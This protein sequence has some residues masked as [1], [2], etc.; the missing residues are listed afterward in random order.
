SKLLVAMKFLERK[1]N[2]LVNNLKYFE[3]YLKVLP[4]NSI[5][6]ITF[7]AMLKDVD[8]YD[9]EKYCETVNEIDTK[10]KTY[11]TK[12]AIEYFKN[13][14]YKKYVLKINEELVKTPRLQT[15]VK[16]R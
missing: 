8:I 10:N 2:F 9:I 11:L 5:Q 16:I 4:I 7:S 12:E 3:C 14:P 1:D 13:G 6:E 15:V